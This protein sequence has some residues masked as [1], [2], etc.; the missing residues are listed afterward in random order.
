LYTEVHWLVC[1]IQWIK[2]HGETVTF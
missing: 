2:M 1:K